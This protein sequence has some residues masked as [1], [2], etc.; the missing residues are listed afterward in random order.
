VSDPDVSEGMR[1]LR[2][3]LARTHPRDHS[4]YVGTVAQLSTTALAIVPFAIAG[5]DPYL[6][7]GASTTG[8][9]TLGVVVLQAYASLSV[10]AFFR[11]RRVPRLWTTLVAPLLGAAGLLTATVLALDNFSTLTGKTSGITNQLPWLLLGAALAGLA[12]GL[13]LRGA[14]PAVYA[15][16]GRDVEVSEL[17]AEMVSS[18]GPVSAIDLLNPAGGSR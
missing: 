16:I 13:W 2:P 5:S 6:G 9:G 15:G 4:P 1:L 7:I 11:R 17:P 10:I 8:L 14:P 3:V 12:Y 18:P